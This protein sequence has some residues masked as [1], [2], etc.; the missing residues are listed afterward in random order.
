[1]KRLQPP[2]REILVVKAAVQ[3]VVLSVRP[4]LFLF[5]RRDGNIASI[6]QSWFLRANRNLVRDKFDWCGCV[7]VSSQNRTIDCRPD[8]H[9]RDLKS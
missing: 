7:S 8:D 3:I 4:K 9:Q 1:M 5:F 2:L 6:L